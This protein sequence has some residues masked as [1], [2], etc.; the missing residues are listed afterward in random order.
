VVTEQLTIGFSLTE[1][2]YADLAIDGPRRDVPLLAHASGGD[3]VFRSSTGGRRGLRGKIA[4][5]QIRQARQIAG[6]TAR[7]ATVFADGEHLGLPLAGFLAMRR[8]RATRLV[9]LGH[10]VDKGWKRALLRI[11]TRLVPRGTLVLHSANQL[12]GIRGVLSRRWEV[13]L[14][15]Y[16]VDT[17]YWR[18]RPVA[19][20]HR[21]LVVAVGSENR[22]YETLVAAVRNLDCDVRIAS[23]SHWARQQAK[24]QSLPANVEFLTETLS[25]ARLRE[26]YAEA[27]VVVVPL[28]PVTNQSGITT[29]LEAMSMGKPVIVTATP[30]QKGTVTGPL[31]TADGLQ[32]MDETRG[33]AIFGLPEP[34]SASGL[35]VRPGDPAGLRRALQTVIGDPRMAEDLSVSARHVVT[36]NFTVE[37]F[38]TRFADVLRSEP[39]AAASSRAEAVPL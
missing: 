19:A 27:S 22:D 9:V 7:N 26:F 37:Q 36:A 5:P 31:I 16:Q 15:P 39:G 8:R 23:G 17:E 29:I 32:E 13:Q 14:L 21:P 30:G 2:E 11:A 12:D 35:Y 20:R 1:S 10:Y 3:L 24:G 25:F 4:G 38:A 34:A 28:H 33:P 18:P 6:L